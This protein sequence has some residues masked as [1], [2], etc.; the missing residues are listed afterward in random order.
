MLDS[1]AWRCLPALAADDFAQII[2]QSLSV[3]DN[4]PMDVVGEL[5]AATLSLFAVANILEVR[6]SVIVEASMLAWFRQ[7]LLGDADT[8]EAATQDALRELANT[9]GGCLKRAALAEGMALTTG[10]PVD[11]PLPTLHGNVRQFSLNVGAQ[12]IVVSAELRTRS[13]VRVRSSSL[14]EGMVLID[15]VCNTKGELLVPAG[16]RLTATTVASLARTLPSQVYVDVCP[17]N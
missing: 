12:R 10:I 15:D 2:G 7:T 4:Q 13:R 17:P 9:T 1:H 16:S 5:H 14:L 11:D 3:N 8:S 6:L